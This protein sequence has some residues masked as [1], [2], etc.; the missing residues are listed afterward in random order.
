MK[1]LVALFLTLIPLGGWCQLSVADFLQSALN[2]PE[3]KALNNQEVYLSTKPYQ[4]SPIRKVALA[5]ESNQLDRTRQDYSFR[6]LPANPWQMQYTNRYFRTYQDIIR[7]DRE[8][9]LRDLIKDR[10]LTVINWVY[11]QEVLTL[12]QEDKLLTEKLISVLQ[13]QLS[14]AYAK[15]DDY[16]EARLELV[17]KTLEL[18]KVRAEINTLR[19]SIEQVT[20]V[21]HRELN[22]KGEELIDASEITNRLAL[23]ETLNQTDE[24]LYRAKQVELANYRMLLEKSNINLGYVQTEYQ[25]FRIEA[26]RRPWNVSVGVTI[27]LFNPNKGDMAFRKLQMIQAEGELE[28]SKL[29]QRINWVVALEKIKNLIERHTEMKAMLQELQPDDLNARLMAIQE[30]N[31]AVALRVKLSMIKIKLTTARLK[32][33]IYLTYIDLLSQQDLLQKQPVRNYL[34][35]SFN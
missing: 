2:A 11:L 8:R 35:V 6:V 5:T 3:I 16:V 30:N 1:T 19:T 7:L 17:N 4:L 29:E 12:R 22:W 10:Y 31:P 23:P 34:S 26:N 13:A 27:P 24:T 32:Q 28:E 15:P 20:G 25:P 9:V 18:E 14:T 21:K 33:E